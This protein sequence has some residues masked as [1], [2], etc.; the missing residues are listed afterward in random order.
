[1]PE[2][3]ASDPLGGMI[4]G[5]SA[6]VVVEDHESDHHRMDDDG[7]PPR[8]EAPANLRAEPGKTYVNVDWNPVTGAEHYDIE[9]DGKI[10][11]VKDTH[12][13]DSHLDP[14]TTHSYRVREV[15]GND[16]EGPFTE[17]VCATTEQGAAEGFIDELLS[18][19]LGNGNGHE[20]A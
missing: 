17:E 2:D 12:Y 10:D 15:T 19:Q 20:D 1:M 6:P 13:V 11:H 8:L 4:P 18:G 14:G 3:I 9:H 7:A 16:V 5:L